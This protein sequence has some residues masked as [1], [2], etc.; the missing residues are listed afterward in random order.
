MDPHGR[1]LFCGF[2][3][4]GKGRY[5]DEIKKNQSNVWFFIVLIQEEEMSFFLLIIVKKRIE[6]MHGLYLIK[7]LTIGECFDILSFVAETT[8]TDQKKVLKKVL[9]QMKII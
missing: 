2:F 1:E 8:A 4:C 6:K 7:Y 5:I 3:D 9:D